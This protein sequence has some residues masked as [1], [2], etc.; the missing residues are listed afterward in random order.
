MLRRISLVAL[1]ATSVIPVTPS[2]AGAGAIAASGLHR[3]VTLFFP[4][5]TT[6]VGEFSAVGATVGPGTI[7]VPVASATP[8]VV[9][10]GT[11]WSGC[12]GGGYGGATIGVVVFTLSAHGPDFDYSEVTVCRVESGVSTCD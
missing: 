8:I 5:P 1:A 7:T 6:V 4:A 11:Q 9:V 10:D 12:V 2:Y 3:C